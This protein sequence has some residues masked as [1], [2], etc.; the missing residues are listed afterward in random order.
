MTSMRACLPRILFGSFRPT[1]AIRSRGKTAQLVR[2]HR[3]SAP[4]ADEHCRRFSGQVLAYTTA[5][6][7]R[8][9]QLALGALAAALEGADSDAQFG[10][11]LGVAVLLQA[12]SPHDRS[13]QR[14]DG[15]SVDRRHE[16]RMGPQRMTPM[17]NV[18]RKAWNSAVRTWRPCRQAPMQPS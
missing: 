9:G 13:A 12:C 8:L 7:T 1:R 3:S 14:C 10:S 15:A 16:A 6:E 18:P 17:P 5:T 4:H 2:T 11:D